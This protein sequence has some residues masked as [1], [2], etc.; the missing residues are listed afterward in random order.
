MSVDPR[1]MSVGRGLMSVD[2]ALMSVAA[3]PWR[4]RCRGGRSGLFPASRCP[5]FPPTYP[6][7]SRTPDGRGG[8]F[9]GFPGCPGLPS[10]PRGASPPFR[11]FAARYRQA[12]PGFGYVVPKR[13]Q[14]KRDLSAI[15]VGVTMGCDL[16]A[17]S[18]SFRVS[19]SGCPDRYLADSREAHGF[20]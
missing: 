4:P 18:E 6:R 12:V 20:P 3:L 7:R 11:Y 1:Q 15:E 10:P 13:L 5:G 16:V 19:E 14:G 8:P 17:Q 9:R 2:I